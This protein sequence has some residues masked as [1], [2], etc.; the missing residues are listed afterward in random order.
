MTKQELQRYLFDIELANKV[1]L[2]TNRH[3]QNLIRDIKHNAGF[4]KEDGCFKDAED[5]E[6]CEEHWLEKEIDKRDET[7]SAFFVDDEKQL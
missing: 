1:G 6:L 4:C 5:G 7:T 3:I 2:A